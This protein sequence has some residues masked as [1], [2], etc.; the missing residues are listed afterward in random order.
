MG[1][2]DRL[3]VEL[4]TTMPKVVS[5]WERKIMRSHMYTHT[6]TTTA[7]ATTTFNNHVIFI[8]T[9]ADTLLLSGTLI[10]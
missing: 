4:G 6:T 5:D 10:V 1:D 3:K 2:V 8:R 9:T 7:D